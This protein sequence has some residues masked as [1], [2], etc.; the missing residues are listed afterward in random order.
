MGTDVWR[1][2]RGLRVCAGAWRPWC[3]DGL[4]DVSLRRRVG[5]WDNVFTFAFGHGVGDG[6]TA[7]CT[8]EDADEGFGLHVFV[9]FDFGRRLASHND[10]WSSH[11]VDYGSRRVPGDMGLGRACRYTPWDFFVERDDTSAV[12]R[13]GGVRRHVLFVFSIHSFNR[14]AVKVEHGGAVVL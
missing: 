2:V 6:S 5:H 13:V 1:S 10:V 9:V 4:V 3:F 8:E 14:V 12:G 7:G 11:V